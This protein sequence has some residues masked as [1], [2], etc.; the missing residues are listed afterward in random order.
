MLI[1]RSKDYIDWNGQ[2]FKTNRKRKEIKTT[3]GN[4]DKKETKVKKIFSKS[5]KKEEKQNKKRFI[6]V[7]GDSV[8]MFICVYCKCLK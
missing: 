7:L 2:L 3:G 5:I 6:L 4:G 8:Y 1:I